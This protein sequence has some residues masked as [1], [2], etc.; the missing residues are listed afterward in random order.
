MTRRT[1]PDGDVSAMRNILQCSLSS[2]AEGS[3]KKVGWLRRLGPEERKTFRRGTVYSFLAI[4]TSLV[5]G[6]CLLDSGTTPASTVVPATPIPTYTPSPLPT[7]SPTPLTNLTRARAEQLV[8]M[9]V[10]SCADQLGRPTQSRVEVALTSNYGPEDKTWVVA[11]S[12]QALGLTLGLWEVKDATG[13]A[14]DLDEVAGSI[15]SPGILCGQPESSLAAGMTPP[16]FSTAPVAAAVTTGEEARLRV[17]LA[18]YGCFEPPPPPGSFTAYQDH[19]ER[20]IVEGRQGEGASTVTYGLWLVDG[21]GVTP[22]DEAAQQ[23]IGANPTCFR[24]P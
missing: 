18:V 12:S 10:R 15:A 9:Q 23:S 22:Y 3:R 14:T 17:W 5:L 19:P 24:E 11:A 13:A 2:P 1:R 21:E 6:A 8:W 7:P 20:W 4:V 16:V